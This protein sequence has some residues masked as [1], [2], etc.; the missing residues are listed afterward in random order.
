PGL[1][2]VGPEIDERQ[3]ADGCVRAERS[4]ERRVDGDLLAN[5]RGADLVES[6]SAVR[7]GNLEPRQIERGG[8]AQ[9]RA[10]ERPVVR[11]EARLDRNPLVTHE[12]GRRLPE[13]ELLLR[14]VVAGEHA[15]GVDR[16]DE[17]PSASE[18]VAH[19]CRH[20]NSYQRMTPRA[21][22]ARA[23]AANAS[24][25]S[26]SAYV[27]LT[28]SLSFRRP[29]QYSVASRGMSS[30]GRPEPY[31]VPTIRFSPLKQRNG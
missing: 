6:E 31:T 20:R 26:P 29:S 11:V 5:I 28:N 7:R 2:L 24:L 12:L 14:Q 27:R 3:R 8:L 9:E 15:L 30:A 10:R 19:V 13:E 4:G 16:L 18:R 17:E 1:L 23:S 25:M 21:P 22:S